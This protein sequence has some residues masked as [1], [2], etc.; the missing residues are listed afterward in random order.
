MD[1]E[2]SSINVYWSEEN[3]QSDVAL[4]DVLEIRPPKKAVL[5]EGAHVLVRWFGS[6]H[7]ATIH[8]VSPDGSSMNVMW[9]TERSQ[10]IVLA[11][12]IVE[13]IKA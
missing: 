4:A 2:H 5:V 3:S 1:E 10:S 8:S 12:D 6:V 13:V 11:A 7:E 9:T